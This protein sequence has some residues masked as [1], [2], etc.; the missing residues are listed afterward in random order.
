MCYIAI[1]KL[2]F[3]LRTFFYLFTF[4]GTFICY[5][6]E[7]SVSGTVL[8]ANNEAI[9]FVNVFLVSE[10]GST[11]IK[12]V[13]TD[14]QG[15][16]K[17]KSLPQNTYILKASFMGYDSFEN[18][19]SL[20]GH[21]E[22][23]PILLQESTES[24]D[25][26][27]ISIKKPTL[28]READ[29][30]IFNIQ[31]TAL[32]E[33]TMLDVLRNTPGVLVVDDAITVKSARPTVFIND[34]QVQLSAEDLNQLL[35]G[36]SANAITSVE[37]ITNPS[38]RYDAES[39]VV[40]N[41]KMSK[42][43]IAGYRGSLS[44]N[45]TQGV[46]PRYDLGSNNFFKNKYI[47]F[48]LNYNYS[49]EKIN[50]DGDDLVNYLDNANS[51]EESWRSKT[52]RNTKS[53]THSL[54]ANFDYF[55]D[56]S[57][58]LSVS[59]NT[60][61]LPYFRYQIDNNT[62]I[63]DENAN[64]LSRY[65]SN[66][67]SRDDKYNLG[68][69]LNYNRTLEKGSLLFNAHYTAYNYERDQGVI[70]NFYDGNN[71]F[72]TASSFNTNSHQ[73]T[74]IFTTKIDYN[75]PLSETSE[76][77][78]GLKFASTQT[79]S[80]ITQF[81]VNLTT[82]N[83]SLNTLNSDAFDYD[84]LIFAAYTNYAFHTEKW[85]INAGLRVE[86]TNIEGQ[87]IST[88]LNNKQEYLKWFPN[89][90]LQYTI[91]DKYNIYTNYKRSIS[92]P[93]YSALNPFRFFLNENYVVSGNPDL[94]PTFSDH[95][96]IGASLWSMFTVEAYYK[97]LDGAISEIPRQNNDTNIIEYINVNFD[98]TTEYGFD[99]VT[100]FN[101]TDSWSL[102]GVTS[103]YKV[104]EE[105]DF[106]NGPVNQSQW[107]NYSL[108]QNSVTFLKDNSLNATLSLTYSSKNLQGFQTIDTRLF[109]NLALTKSIFKKKAVVSLSVGDLFNEEDAKIRVRYQ[110]QSS[111][112]YTDHDNRYI[113][114]GF[115]YKFGNTRLETNQRD[116]E[117]EELDRLDKDG[118]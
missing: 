108:L 46:F 33:G 42:N 44:T 40:L 118:H 62:V 101:V 65:T 81:D 67:L 74:E 106:G 85:S 86:Q 100:Y 98:K 75:V 109:S 89:A 55:I 116:I 107:S 77:E 80:D 103:F 66:N 1:L 96:K 88:N 58:T 69:D 115:R 90:S 27:N 24:L 83:E 61:Y 13:T 50:R 41:I 29:R 79:V 113:K 92:R 72:S 73:E 45:Y 49:K 111:S 35:E 34:K 39:G 18:I 23:Q 63:T 60:L 47:S 51:L 76:L 3:H 95:V 5:A 7:F 48:N 43:L 117:L 21:L 94:V 19:I 91:S 32:V 4:C 102:Y 6:Q 84:E 12:G 14:E 25:V 20:T 82:G 36:S 38:A 16:F 54:N 104:E 57:N 31:N 22:L 59:S 17:L 52:N 2:T 10:D 70:T 53:E 105:T 8:D 87:S 11:I 15:Y 37:V 28:K 56:D 78:T 114:F 97:N 30:L 26:V 9:E 68:F 71:M 93:D 112:G 110:N 64:F 99:F